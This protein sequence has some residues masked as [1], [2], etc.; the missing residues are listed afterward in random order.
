MIIPLLAAAFCVSFVIAAVLTPLLAG[1]FG[2]MGFLDYFCDQISNPIIF[3]SVSVNAAVGRIV[4]FRF[5]K[6]R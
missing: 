5:M 3:K 4:L 6:D 2:R 1:L